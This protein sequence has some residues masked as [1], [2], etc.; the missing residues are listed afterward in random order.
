MASQILYIRAIIN[1]LIIEIPTR[2]NNPYLGS[3]LFSFNLNKLRII[4]W[5]QTYKIR[6][7]DLLLFTLLLSYTKFFFLIYRFQNCLKIF[8]FALPFE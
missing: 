4:T 2:D 1:S 7:S 5:H 8:L 3:N 6:F